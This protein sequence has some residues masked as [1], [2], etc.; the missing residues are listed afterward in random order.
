MRKA[1]TLRIHPP[2]DL[3]QVALAA[4]L[5]LASAGALAQQETTLNTVTVTD[6]AGT[7]LKTDTAPSSK[8]TAPLIDTPKT[9]QVIN[10]EVIRQT[11]STSLAEALRTSPGITFGAGE[12]GNPVGDRPFLRGSDAQGSIFVDGMRD[13]AARS[14]EVYNIESIEV[15]KGADSAYAGRGGAGGSINMQTKKAKNENFISGDVGLGTDNYRRA[16]LDLNRKL[17]DTTGFRLNAM[18]HDADV[19]GRDGPDNKRWGIAP[20]LTFGMG[21]PTEITLAYEHMQSNDMPDS[22]VPY[23]MGNVSALKSPTFIG[24][25]YGGNR[26]NWYGLKARDFRKEKSDMF[27]AAIEH[28]FSDTSKIRNATRWSKGTQDYVWTQP[29]DSQSNVANGK[30]WRRM[31]SRY[32]ESKTLQ[33]L[34]EFTGQ[35]YSGSIKHQFAIGLELTREET[36]LDSYKMIDASGKDISNTNQCVT[37]L[38]PYMC[39]SLYSPNGN[40]PWTG[41]VVRNNSFTYYKANTAALYAFDTV[42]LSPQWLVNAGLRYDRYRIRQWNATTDYGHDDNLLN[43]QLGVVY[44]LQPNASIYASTGTSSKPGGGAV[45]QGSEDQ[46][47][48]IINADA[49][50]PEKT[51]SFEL[52]TK[53]DVLNQQ[54]SLTAAIFRNQTQNA[55]I[56][57]AFGSVTMAGEK[58][59]NGLE[60]GF[61]GRVTKQWDVFGGYTYMD[62]EQ[63]HAGYSCRNGVCS[64][65]AAEGQAFPNT[66][67]HS[68]SLW[69]SYRFTPQLTVGV[70]AFGQSEVV[71]GYSFSS[72]GSLIKK[73][74][75]GYMRYDA[76]A[77]YAFSKNL[78]LQL[79][80]YNLTNKVY[81]STAYAAHYAGMGPGRSAVASLKFSY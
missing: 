20:T 71:G 11:G 25:T 74:T 50:K 34:T 23:A 37:G 35:A 16:T 28:K 54:L 63:K 1:A 61:A 6:T 36:D 51:R 66:P 46:A 13:I 81:Y 73:G 62:S 44:K 41:S 21:T 4:C 48:N 32:A 64:A 79:N 49:L 57:D 18:T 69:T 38:S 76:M 12:G 52:G 31:N 14:R 7:S 56:T 29:D 27:T 70:G 5:A 65:S 67:R 68:F 24:P 75:A 19:P 53:W 9:V 2:A 77:S 39:T 55:R 59:V 80:L 22:G 8:F 33:N 40:D 47:I 15:I 58:I 72:N 60:L 17:G 10:E 30:V 43:Y 42:T 26:D 45:G 78:S 3:T